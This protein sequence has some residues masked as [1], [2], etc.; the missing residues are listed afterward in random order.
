MMA[1]H[2]NLCRQGI[3]AAGHEDLFDRA[4][5]RGV[6]GFARGPPGASPTSKTRVV[7][8]SSLTTSVFSFALGWFAPSA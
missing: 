6:E 8:R 2:E 4:D 5:R 7:P 3:R 1:D